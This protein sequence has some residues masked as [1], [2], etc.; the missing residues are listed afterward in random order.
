LGGDTS[1]KIIRT[2]SLLHFLKL[3]ELCNC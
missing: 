2:I 1:H 3:F